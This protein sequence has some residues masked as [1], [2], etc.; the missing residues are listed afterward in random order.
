MTRR[1]QTRRVK[2]R[3]I[4]IGGGAT[5]SVQSMTNTPTADAERT[6]AQIRALETTGC[7]IIRFAVPDAEAAAAIGKIRLGTNLPLVADIH[8]DHRL[9]IAAMENGVDKIRINPGN[10]GSQ[11]KVRNLVACAKHHGIPIRIG[12][13]A[14]SLPRPILAQ[15]G[16]PTAEGLVCAAMEHVALLEANGFYDIIVSLKASSVSMTVDA[17]SQMAERVAYPLHLGVTEAGH[18]QAGLVKSAMGIGALL[19]KGVGDTIRVSLTGDPLQEV[20]AGREILA[21]AGL[22]RF[23]PE[24]ISCPTCG[25][26]GYDLESA[27]IQVKEK[28]SGVSLPIR[29]A[30]MGCVVNGPGEAVEADIG[31][32]GG[33]DRGALF[34]HGKLERTLPMNELIDALVEEI[35][36]W[37]QAP[38]ERDRETN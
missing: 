25:R 33:K 37:P 7:E 8:F 28:L 19:L 31:L 4:C 17:Y 26:C 6:L 32:A 11:E 13:N 5:V 27:V 29:V 30:I 1:T 24:I 35:L 36:S 23:G 20:S 2:V 9:A 22:R 18:A 14:G 21:A 3:D 38:S 16:G 34:K 12:V 15:Y 10:I